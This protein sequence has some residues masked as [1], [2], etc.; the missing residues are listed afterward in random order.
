MEAAEPIAR[1]RRTRTFRT[2]EEKRLVVEQTLSPGVSVATVARVHGINANQV[3][4][5]RKLYEAGQLE[6]VATVSFGGSGGRSMR[7]NRG[8]W[9]DHA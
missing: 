9:A 5:W 4:H 2:T 8:A 6:S 1:R 7:N 3:F